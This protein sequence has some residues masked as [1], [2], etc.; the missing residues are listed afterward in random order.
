MSETKSI[1]S[2]VKSSH[3]TDNCRCDYSYMRKKGPKF[4]GETTTQANFKAYPI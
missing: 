2:S 1:A 4:E 3:Q